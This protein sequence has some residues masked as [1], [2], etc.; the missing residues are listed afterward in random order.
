MEHWVPFPDPGPPRMNITVG[1]GM[2]CGF[3]FGDIVAGEGF[4]CIV[5]CCLGRDDL[6]VRCWRVV[7]I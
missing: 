3:E 5:S 7:G 4:V 1:S 6:A 2:D